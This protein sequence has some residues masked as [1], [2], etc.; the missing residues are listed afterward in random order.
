MED[1][2]CDEG[3][4]PDN[5]GNEE[6][7]MIIENDRLGLRRLKCK[8]LNILTE[9]RSDEKIY[10]YEPTFL[11]ELQGTAG[12][13]L[14]ALCGMKLDTDRQCILGI[15]EKKEPDNIVGLAELYDYKTSGKVISIGYRL[16]PEYWGRGIGTS[17][18]SALIDFIKNNTDVELVTAHVMPANIAS[19]RILIKNGFKYLL[20]KTEDWG[21]D[22]PTVA[23]VYTLDL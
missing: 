19:S 5:E 8:D 9:M 20:T 15:Y 14:E 18:V 16:R 1:D 23:D 13:A 6:A 21:H 12:E 22:E 4:K 17:C 3:S 10:R 2:N 11:A 7:Y